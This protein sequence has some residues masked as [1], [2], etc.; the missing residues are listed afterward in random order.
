MLQTLTVAGMAL[1]Y[2]WRP[3]GQMNVLGVTAMALGTAVLLLDARD[4]Q[5]GSAFGR[6]LAFAPLQWFG[7]CSY[8]L[9]L[10]HLVVLGAMRTV[11]PPRS[12]AGDEKLWLLAGFLALSAELSAVVARFYAEPLNRGI[13]QFLSERLARVVSGMQDFPPAHERR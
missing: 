10:F 13:K 6:S 9:Y 11:L 4:R 8:E 2:L 12:A 7:R 1:L 3:I 5:A